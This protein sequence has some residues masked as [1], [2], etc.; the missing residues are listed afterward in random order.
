MNWAAR[1]RFRQ[2]LRES[3][4]VYPLAGV[5]LGGLLALLTRQADTS[6]TV[7][8]GWRYSPS[9]AGYLATMLSELGVAPE[10]HVIT[11]ETLQEVEQASATSESS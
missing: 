9:T 10:A 4:W 2:Y 11:K 7:P 8:A 3:L 5:I 6:L 1:F